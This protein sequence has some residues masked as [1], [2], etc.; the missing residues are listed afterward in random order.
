[1]QTNNTVQYRTTQ[2]LLKLE[3]F[4]FHKNTGCYVF[5]RGAAEKVGVRK[6]NVRLSRFFHIIAMTVQYLIMKYVNR[7][8]TFSDIVYT[9]QTRYVKICTAHI[10]SK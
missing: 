1:M 7:S 6:G 10:R 4:N 9:S 5:I 3:R 8:L 2:Y